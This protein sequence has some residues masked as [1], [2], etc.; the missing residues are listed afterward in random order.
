VRAAGTEK[1]KKRKQRRRLLRS[2]SLVSF[3]SLGERAVKKDS[4][5]RPHSMKVRTAVKRLCDAC[6]VVLRR[7]RVY[8][9]CKANP[10][11]C[12]C[13]LYAGRRVVLGRAGKVG[14][15]AAASACVPRNPLTPL[16]HSPHP[17]TTHHSTS[18]AKA[19]TPWR[20]AWS[21]QPRRRALC[22]AFFFVFSCSLPDAGAR[23]KEN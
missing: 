17:P 19:C 16:T 4:R 14:R 9:V 1:K 7:G 12:V 18:S 10:K 5:P 2:H 20:A 3:F 8:V 6:R 13:V 21:R 15:A 11:V 22:G 23:R